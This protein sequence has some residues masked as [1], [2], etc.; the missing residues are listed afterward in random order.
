MNTYDPRSGTPR[1]GVEL[2]ILG[3]KFKSVLDK[4][5]L[6]QKLTLNNNGRAIT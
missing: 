3:S 4:A 5:G 1:G 2:K 6:E